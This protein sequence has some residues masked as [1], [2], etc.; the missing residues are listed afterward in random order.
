MSSHIRS[1]IDAVAI[2]GAAATAAVLVRRARLAPAPLPAPGPPPKPSALT[3]PW[4]LFLATSALAL[5][6]QVLFNAY[7]LAAHGGD[8][9]FIQAYLG[10]AYFHM[11]FDFP[12]V[13]PIASAL[14]REGAAFWLSPSLLRV[15]AILELPFAVFAYLAITRLFDRAAARFLLRSPLGWLGAASFTIILCLIELLLHN[16]W[17]SSDLWM[18]GVSFLLFAPTLVYLG[19][20]ERGAPCFPENDGQPRS[21][22]ALLVA[23]MG[24]IAMAGSLL[25]LYDITLLYNLGHVKELKPLLL[26]LLVMGT[27]SVLVGP[28]LNGPIQRRGDVTPPP[29]SVS[30]ITMVASSFAIAFFVP[31]LAVRY[32]LG[33]PISDWVGLGT[34]AAAVVGGLVWASREP[35][36][37]RGRW[38]A[39]LAGGALAGCVAVVVARSMFGRIPMAEAALVVY[40]ALFLGPFVLTWRALEALG[41][42]A[43]GAR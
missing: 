2:T 16:P 18:R 43:R 25:L 12:L 24:A 27:S 7:I 14:G 41:L 9:S 29:A 42:D 32:G 34:L 40:A 20:R 10:R 39:G 36:L 22:T 28:R 3:H 17:T 38:L 35:G 5:A 21:L 19:H 4:T 30:A 23:F 33:H 26:G 6:N 15:N 13:R 31:S 1:L 37:V 11:D 8:P